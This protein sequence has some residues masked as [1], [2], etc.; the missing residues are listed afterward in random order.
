MQNKRTGEHSVQKNNKEAHIPHSFSL[1]KDRTLLLAQGI[2]DVDGFD[3]KTVFAM[4]YG[5]RMTIKGS[6]LKVT[7]F[8]AESGKLAVE[9]KIESVTYSPALARK[10]GFFAKIFR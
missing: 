3:D 2:C 4:P 7:E 1:E 10:A 5:L 8:S 9:G 6:G